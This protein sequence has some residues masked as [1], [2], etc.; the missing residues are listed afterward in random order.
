MVDYDKIIIIIIII[1][2]LLF[3]FFILN[4]KFSVFDVKVPIV[5]VLSYDAWL[6]I[7]SNVI[8]V[9]LWRKVILL[10]MAFACASITF[11]FHLVMV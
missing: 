5:K 8:M 1:I 9:V 10:C 11:Y 6:A 4:S 2:H 3:P 7:F